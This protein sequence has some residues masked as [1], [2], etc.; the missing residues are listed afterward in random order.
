L[1]QTAILPPSAD[2]YGKQVKSPSL[3]C[4]Y[5]NDLVFKIRR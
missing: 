1:P 4:F 5:F 2:N 3:G